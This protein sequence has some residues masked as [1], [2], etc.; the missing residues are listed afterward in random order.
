[1][2]PSLCVYIH[3]VA[4]SNSCKNV[5]LRSCGRLRGLVS[6]FLATRSSQMNAEAA[7]D[8]YPECKL[9]PRSIVS[10]QVRVGDMW[11]GVVWACI[12]IFVWLRGKICVGEWCCEVVGSC[13]VQLSCELLYSTSSQP[14]KN[15]YVCVYVCVCEGVCV[16]VC[17][18]VMNS[19]HRQYCL[20]VA[21]SVVVFILYWMHSKY[22]VSIIPR[23]NQVCICVLFSVCLSVSVYFSVQITRSFVIKITYTAAVVCPLTLQCDYKG[24]SNIC[25]FEKMSVLIQPLYTRQVVLVH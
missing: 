7:N 6:Y 15:L 10:V 4:R 2:C 12:V 9:N 25:S 20:I 24:H 16:C 1:M 17:L 22:T 14:D 21:C 11:L 5:V 19:L 23:D 13:E 3:V 8:V 18:E